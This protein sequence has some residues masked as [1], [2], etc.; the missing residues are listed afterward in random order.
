MNDSGFVHPH[1]GLRQIRGSRMPT[2]LAGRSTCCV[3]CQRCRATPAPGR[4][5]DVA[6]TSGQQQ[7]DGRRG[8]T[9]QH[10][11]QGRIET[12]LAAGPPCGTLDT[13]GQEAVSFAAAAEHSAFVE[14]PSA[15]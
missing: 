6:A 2:N 15:M 3:F 11:D 1:A 5:N 9:D 4:R 12:R 13:C 14:I 7:E 8:Q 10:F